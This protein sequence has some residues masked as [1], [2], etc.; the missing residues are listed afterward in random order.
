MT[1]LDVE[2]VR[3][4]FRL[5]PSR[6]CRPGIFENAGGSYTCRQVIDRLHRFYTQRKVQPYGRMR[7]V[8]RR[9][10][11]DEARVRLAAMMNVATDE[12]GFGLDKQNT[13]V[14][15]ELLPTRCTRVTW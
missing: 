10:E 13:Y 5:F 1:K 6:P 2:F 8:P 12:L 3:S 9:D 11:M 14:L 7:Q 15:A 4:Q